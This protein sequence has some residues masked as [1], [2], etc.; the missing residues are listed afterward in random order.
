MN[1]EKHVVT[2]EKL[3]YFRKAAIEKSGGKHN[4]IESADPPDFDPHEAVGKETADGVITEKDVKVMKLISD[5]ARTREGRFLWYGYRL[6]T[7]FWSH[8]IL[9][10]AGS[11]WYAETSDGQKPKLNALANAYIGAWVERDL[12]WDWEH[13][14][15][16]K[17]EEI[18]KKSQADL[19]V[20]ECNRPDLYDF[21]QSGAKLI[22]SHA[23]NDDTIPGDG[24]IDYYKRVCERMGG[25]EAVR[26][27][28]RLFMSPG[29]GHTDIQQPG[30]SFTLSDGMIAL[31][32]WVEEGIAPETI[33]AGWYNFELNDYVLTG[34]IPMYR[35]GEPNPALDIQ[36]T[37]AY[38]KMLD[39]KNT[40]NP[41]VSNSR[42]SS[43]S[44]LLEIMEDP[45]GKKILDDYLGELLGNSA[46]KDS[47]GVNIGDLQKF[48]S[49]PELKKKIS[50]AVL[51]LEKLG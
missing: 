42:L 49:I 8:G 10:E 39:S 2:P 17:F 20:L 27:Y 3:E 36:E 22:V 11:F 48:T 43:N 45:K 19:G 29:G 24:T 47:F 1:E 9:G 44:T 41:G 25:E 31:M 50:E 15:Y 38:G 23:V 35:I 51:E 37:P 4:F 46:F 13:L 6:G 32:R 14:D 21:C 33:P 40:P 5:G 7:H 18:F 26:K 34:K 30:L 16:K 28:M 12:N